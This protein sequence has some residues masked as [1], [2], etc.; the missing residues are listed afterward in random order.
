M[1]A[2]MDLRSLSRLLEEPFAMNAALLRTERGAERDV[3]RELRDVAAVSGVT[4][5]QDAYRSLMD[6]LGASMQIS[7]AIIAIFASVIAFA[8]IYNTT[9]VSLMERRRELASL[10]VLGFSTREVGR[11][12]YNENALL[13]ALGLLLGIPL[14]L[15]LCRLLVEAYETELYRFPFHFEYGTVVYTAAMTVLF[16]GV[17]NWAVHRKV[18]RLDIVEVLKAR[19]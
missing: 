19:E 16:V 1:G 15:G 12:L 2:Y 13:S 10:R 5:K 6:T 9:T 7:N 14:G 8:I 11:I 18:R 17:A 3:A 4:V